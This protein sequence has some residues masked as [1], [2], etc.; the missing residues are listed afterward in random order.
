M[1]RLP[2]SVL[3]WNRSVGD[4]FRLDDSTHCKLI[5]KYKLGTIE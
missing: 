4:T 5:F 2:Y 3:I 1:S